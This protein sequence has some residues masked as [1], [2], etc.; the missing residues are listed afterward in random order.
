MIPSETHSHDDHLLASATAFVR[1]EG[2]DDAVADDAAAEAALRSM[3]RALPRPRPAV[4]FAARVMASV[5]TVPAALRRPVR[6]L[7]RRH[8]WLVAAAGLCLAA[9]SAYL[10]PVVWFL[11]GQLEWGAVT[12]SVAAGF[13]HLLTFGLSLADGLA[14]LLRTAFALLRALVLFAMSPQVLFVAALSTAVAGV[15][16][17]LL[18]ELLHSPRN[19]AHASS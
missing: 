9:A 15:S 5:Q 14:F 6:D 11:L 3:F 8:R 12:A 18:Q 17:R 4:D 19:P 13:G 10:L 1:A 16:L 7:P 2:K